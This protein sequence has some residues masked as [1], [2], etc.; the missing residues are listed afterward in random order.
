MTMTATT[1]GM[2]KNTW[3]AGPLIARQ[4]PPRPSCETVDEAAHPNTCQMHTHTHTQKTTKKS[5]WTCVRAWL[6]Q[7]Q[8]GGI[9]RWS[10]REKVAKRLGWVAPAQ[11]RTT[12]LT[13]PNTHKKNQKKKSKEKITR[14]IHKKNS[15]KHKMLRRKKKLR[16][17]GKRHD[18]VGVPCSWM[19]LHVAFNWR[20]LRAVHARCC[21]SVSRWT[22]ISH[23]LKNTIINSN[24]SKNSNNSNKVNIFHTQI[25][26]V[27]EWTK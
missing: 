22:I 8:R 23:F 5:N 2:K 6:L 20:R 10:E 1:T 4:R 27:D 18:V 24:N 26:C 25:N 7:T 16:C 9:R 12:N 15:S 13:K 19:V 14:K 11:T 21:A 3:M 17:G